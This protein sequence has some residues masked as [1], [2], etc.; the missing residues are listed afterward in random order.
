MLKHITVRKDYAVQDC[1]IL[2][3]EPKMKLALTNIIINAIEA[4]SNKGGQLKI[5]T[6]SI[7]GKFILH[8]E[9]NGCGISKTNL[10]K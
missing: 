6:K 1:K 4:M 5:F 9:D 7:A 8:I 3:N 2:L 10:S